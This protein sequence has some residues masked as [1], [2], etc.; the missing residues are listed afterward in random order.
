MALVDDARDA[1]AD[2]SLRQTIGRLSRQLAAAKASKDEL[3]A[4]VYQGAKDA[5][6]GIVL[7]PV[8]KPAPDRRTGKPEV[9]VPWLSDWQ[10]AK[11]TPS[12]SSA[13][14]EQRVELYADKV[15]T[16]TGIQ[17][18]DHPVRDAHVIITGDLVEGELIFPGQHW[19][20][21]A[22]LY[23]QV[24]VSGPRILGNFLRRMLGAFDRVN[25]TAV[26][27]NHGRIGGRAS[28]D[29]NPESNAD[30]MLYR[31]TQQLLAG[32]KRLSWTIPDGGR[33][34]NWY[35]IAEIGGYRALCIH[36][37]QFRGQS[38]MPWYGIAKKAG[39]W[40]MGAIDEQY[41]EILFG[42]YHQPTRLTLN[43]VTARCSGSTESHNTYA[44]EQL[45]A[46]GRP[47]QNL[48]FV[49]PSRGAVTA[50]YCVW[51]D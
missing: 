42:H 37:D 45:A 16:L 36:G 48:L 4:A 12:Y 47:S 49:S 8:P 51:L 18:A 24:C 6:S 29:Y 20:I 10:L 25:V 2:E 50:E 15:L 7:P 46:V 39:G 44:Q 31:I 33:E 17:R 22:S 32:E 21:D 11:I 1:Q 41:S 40:A 3:V 9:A 13:V 14:C 26:I 30:R 19:L 35:A 34:R 28:R 27:G 5:A 38:G 23:E 43:S